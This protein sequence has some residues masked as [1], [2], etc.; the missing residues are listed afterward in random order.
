[1]TQKKGNNKGVKENT[2]KLFFIQVR[3][4]ETK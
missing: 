3:Y 1:M 4:N 2:R